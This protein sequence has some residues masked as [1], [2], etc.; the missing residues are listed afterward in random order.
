MWA[1]SS[2]ETVK[3][4]AS[5]K[6]VEYR[7]LQLLCS[8]FM[9]GNKSNIK[10]SNLSS[11]KKKPRLHQSRWILPPFLL[12]L[13]YWR[14]KSGS[15]DS[16][17]KDW[18]VAALLTEE[19]RSSSSGPKEESAVMSSPLMR[20]QERFD[21]LTHSPPQL[22]LSVFLTFSKCLSVT[23]SP[24]FSSPPMCHHLCRPPLF[25]S[26]SWAVCFPS[27]VIWA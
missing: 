12:S 20:W 22:S 7:Q 13:S 8:V 1:K 19:W 17:V 3:D 21:H 10:K 2:G 11:K 9:T 6:S 25:F 26:F 23:F 5:T 16:A 24:T 15:P 18:P 27:L 4:S 14:H